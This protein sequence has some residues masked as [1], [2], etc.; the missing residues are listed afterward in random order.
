MDQTS[1][2]DLEL[3]VFELAGTRYA[4]ELRSV[5]EVVRAVL[6]A[7]L[8]DAPAVIEGIV[9]V[10]G[11]LVPVYD[12]RARFGLGARALDPDERLVV[13]WT[14][15][16][17]AAFRCDR[18]EWVE[19]VDPASIEP[20]D[21][22]PGTGRHIAGVAR[23]PEGLVLIQQLDAFLEDAEAAVLD[24]ALSAHSDRAAE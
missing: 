11:E 7:P 16:R 9:D 15:S 20:A 3:L 14:G 17:L 10:R 1:A 18:T 2:E 4:L 19:H 13:A 5:R 6:I 12:L 23:L 24:D 22:V 21:S 8:P